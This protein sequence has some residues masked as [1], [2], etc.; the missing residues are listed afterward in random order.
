MIVKTGNHTYNSHVEIV[1]FIWQI[2]KFSGWAVEVYK[3]GTKRWQ[4]SCKQ[5]ENGLRVMLWKV[6]QI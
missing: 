6:S 5:D 3:T 2:C 1:V 4:E